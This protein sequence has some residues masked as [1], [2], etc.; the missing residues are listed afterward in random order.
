MR[1]PINQPQLGPEETQAVAAV[2]QSGQLVRGSKAEEFEQAFAR[3]Q[4]CPFGIATSSGTSALTAALI[5]HE[6]GPGDE[7]IVP[8]FTFFATAS[9]VLAT[10]ARPRF[11]DIDP[12]SLTLCPDA[13]ASAIKP[14][15]RAVI[16]V[17]LY[18]QLT[19][20]S[21]VAELCD[22]RG[23]TLIEDAA[24]AHGAKIERRQDGPSDSEPSAQMAGSWGTACFS[25][26]PSKSM[27]TAEG[28]MVLTKD[29]RLATRLRQICNQGR[30]SSGLHTRVGFNFRMSEVSAAIGV[31]QLKKLPAWLARRQQN[32]L[33]YS[34]NLHNVRCPKPQPGSTPAFQLYTIRTPR[35]DA[36]LSELRR[37]GI[38]ARVYYTPGLHRQ[39]ALLELGLGASLPRTDRASAEVLSLP[40]HPGV[41]RD[42]LQEVC[43]LVNRYA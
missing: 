35:R 10:G 22:R 17:H 24:Q 5:A 20:L 32:A 29:E 43:E 6:I 14:R 2:L 21:P 11:A 42:L 12:E 34:D 36:L 7:V 31:E 25:F 38:D 15:T 30:D 19:D 4:D 18:G 41:T 37:A 9:A 16:A 27:T 40:V 1:L 3:F 8:A 39:P 23:L 28:G 13:V 33:Y 26:H